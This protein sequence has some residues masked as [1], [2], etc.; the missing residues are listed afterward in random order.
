MEIRTVGI[1]LAGLL[2]A[3]SLSS[4]NLIWKDDFNDQGLVGQNW[5]SSGTY[6]VPWLWTNDPCAAKS[7]SQFPFFGSTSAEPGYI[8]YDS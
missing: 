7:F 2:L 5:V 4:Q 6:S 1:L 8:Y 3:T